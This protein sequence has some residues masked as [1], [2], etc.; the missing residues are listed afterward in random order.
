MGSSSSGQPW[1]CGRGQ[2]RGATTPSPTWSGWPASRRYVVRTDRRVAPGWEGVRH[3]PQR[4]RKSY[5]DTLV[6]RESIA[7]VRDG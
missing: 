4:S 5:D 2:G 3:A 1:R 6:A 7:R